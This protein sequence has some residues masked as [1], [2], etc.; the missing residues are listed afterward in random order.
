MG[1]LPTEWD[2]LYRDAP[3]DG[4]ISADGRVRALVLE[5]ARP[6]DWEALSAVWRGVQA[7]LGLPA[8]AIAVSGV[9]GYQLW[10][11]LAQAIPAAQGQAFLQ[12]LR[13]HY[14]PTVAATRV[15]LFPLLDAG[16]LRHAGPVP[17]L[18]GDSGRW[19]AF[20]APDLASIF[21]DEPWLDVRPS[22]EAQAS[23]LARLECARPAAFELACSRLQPLT[24]SPLPAQ[25]GTAGTDLE[26]RRFLQDVLND[27]AIALGL[28]IAAAQALLT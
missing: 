18:L 16:L 26:P 22:A 2:R 15:R 23:V 12:A 19:A 11:S 4:L 17:A 3:G 21:S 24:A 9:D 20:V 27:P 6:A 5:L 8:P 14:L 10:F 1:D 28:R 13:L 7:E 25:A